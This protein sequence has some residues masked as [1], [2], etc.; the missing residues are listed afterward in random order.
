METWGGELWADAEQFLKACVSVLRLWASLNRQLGRSPPGLWTY[1]EHLEL[2]HGGNICL[3]VAHTFCH[4]ALLK[5][6]WGKPTWQCIQRCIQHVCM[7]SG[8]LNRCL[9]LKS[10]LLLI[11]SLGVWRFRCRCPAGDPDLCCCCCCCFMPF[12][13]SWNSSVSTPIKLIN[14]AAWRCAVVSWWGFF[15]LFFYIM[16]CVQYMLCAIYCCDLMCKSLISLF[17]QCIVCVVSLRLEIT[18][19]N[20]CHLWRLNV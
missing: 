20:S 11:L 18:F 8:I 7:C 14:K 15:C 19:Y 9:P 10:C 2:C 13:L 3:V 4:H 17:W 6:P 12:C 5:E 1:R 16:A